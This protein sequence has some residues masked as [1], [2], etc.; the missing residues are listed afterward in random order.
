MVTQVLNLTRSGLSDYVV[1][2]ATAVIL[3]VYTV[4]VMGFF[5]LTPEMSYQILVGFFF[6]CT[7]ADSQHARGSV[8]RC[9][10]LDRHVDHRHRLSAG[11]ARWQLLHGY[12]F[13][14]PSRVLA[15]AIYLSGLGIPS[16]LA[17]LGSFNVSNS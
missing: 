8:Y 1:Q 14:V 4:W 13:C 9:P 7:Y 11:S 16:G 10:C 5:L 3:T 17:I 15:G 6:Q 2:R 12:S